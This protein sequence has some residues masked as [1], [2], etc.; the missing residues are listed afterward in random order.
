MMV[1]VETISEENISVIHAPEQQRRGEDFRVK[2]REQ[3][4][5]LVEQAIHHP[6]KGD[7]DIVE[8]A[9]HGVAQL[10]FGTAPKSRN[11]YSRPTRSQNSQTTPNSQTT[12]G[13]A[14]FGVTGAISATRIGDA[15][16]EPPDVVRGI[17]HHDQP[18]QR[19][20][21]QRVHQRRQN[22]VRQMEVPI[23]QERIG[24]AHGAPAVENQAA[25]RIQSKKE[26]RGQHA[27]KEAGP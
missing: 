12:T 11:T 25:A 2:E 19:A 6:E 9:V 3:Q 20:A 7:A 17:R 5:G 16:E 18:E 8:C 4:P 24:R 10:A 22:E 27:E 15:A 14:A 23:G 13:A 21:E 1:A 26:S